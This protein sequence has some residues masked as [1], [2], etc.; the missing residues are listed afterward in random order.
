LHILDKNF[1]WGHKIYRMFTILP[2]YFCFR[3]KNYYCNECSSE[4]L[5]ISN[6]PNL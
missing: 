6:R 3:F 1:C 4:H 2:S 5:Q